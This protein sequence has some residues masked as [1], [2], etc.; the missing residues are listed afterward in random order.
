MKLN[1]AT[2]DADAGVRHGPAHQ[3]R[4]ADRPQGRQGPAGVPDLQVLRRPRQLVP[5]GRSRRDAARSTRSRFNFAKIE[6]EYKQQRAGRHARARRPV[7]V[8]PEEEQDLLAAAGSSSR[9][10]NPS[11]PSRRPSRPEPAARGEPARG[12]RARANAAGCGLRR[13][14]DPGA[15]CDR[16][17]APCPLARAAVVPA[18][19]RGRRRA[20]RAPAPF[21]PRRAC[22]ARTRCRACSPTRLHGRLAGGSDSSSR[23]PRTYMAPRVSSSRRAADRVGPG[24]RGEGN[25]DHVPGVHRPSV[26]LAHLTVR[27]QWRARARR[28]NR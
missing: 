8:R 5:D 28:R 22:R 17:P 26:A 20:G 23:T 25:A 6:V 21:P 15:A 18:A 9:S 24:G 1:K 27:G 7:R 10:R 4:D 3:D 12:G 19:A 11:A 14:P 16:R 2:P 13:A